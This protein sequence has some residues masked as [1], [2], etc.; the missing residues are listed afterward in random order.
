MKTLL[1][2]SLVLTAFALQACTTMAMRSG[3][4]YALTPAETEIVRAALAPQMLDPQ[5]TRNSSAI[6]SPPSQAARSQSADM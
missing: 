2:T 1:L 3:T 4:S 5:S 6:W